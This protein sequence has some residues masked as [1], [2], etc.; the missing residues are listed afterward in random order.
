MLSVYVGEDKF[1]KGVSIYLKKHLYANSVT[2]DLWEGIQE[3]SGMYPRCD[4]DS[5]WSIHSNLGID[6]PKMMDNWVKKVSIT[7]SRVRR[8][9]KE[10]QMGYPVITVTEVKD[11]IHVR[12]D[13]FLETGPAEPKYNET[14]W[15]VAKHVLFVIDL[16]LCKGRSL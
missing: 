8:W 16:M 7:I 3:A 4:D 1:L 2:N 13:R 10:L 5:A 6:V 9:L 14:I 15:Y 11:G 12:Q